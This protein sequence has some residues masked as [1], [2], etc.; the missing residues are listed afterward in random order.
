LNVII[1]NGQFNRNGKLGIYNLAGQLVYEQKAELNEDKKIIIPSDKINSLIEGTYFIHF[2]STRIKMMA[3]F[4]KM[5][6]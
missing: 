3:K 1:N 5:Q 6:D 4:V 2:N